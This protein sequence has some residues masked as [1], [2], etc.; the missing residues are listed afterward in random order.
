M[1]NLV[2][3]MDSA[4]QVRPCR[5]W[6]WVPHLSPVTAIKRS[7]DSIV[8]SDVCPHSARRTL[9]GLMTNARV[10]C[11]AHTGWLDD[12]C[13]CAMAGVSSGFTSTIYRSPPA[14]TRLRYGEARRTFE[15]HYSLFLKSNSTYPLMFSQDN[16]SCQIALISCCLQGQQQLSN[17]TDLMLFA[18]TTAAVKLH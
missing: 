15:Q 6:A 7:G 5:P 18:R 11:P 14:H 13:T 8:C 9:A 3:S 4:L 1:R 17:Y 16:S 12:Q 2:I 10:V